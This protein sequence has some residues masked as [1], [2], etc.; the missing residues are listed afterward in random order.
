[1][2]HIQRII[3]LPRTHGEPCPRL[4]ARAAILKGEAAEVAQQI[5]ELPHWQNDRLHVLVQRHQH[6][7]LKSHA[8]T[9]MAH[10]HSV[11]GRAYARSAGKEPGA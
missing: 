9:L 5:G 8:A 2:S 1:V 3:P 11:L 6:F 7:I 4:L 10:G